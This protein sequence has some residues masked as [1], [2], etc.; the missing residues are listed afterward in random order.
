VDFDDDKLKLLGWGG[1]KPP[2]ALERPGQARALE[3]PREVE[4][5]IFPDWKSP[6]EGGKVAAYKIERRERPWLDAG[7]AMETEATLHNQE[8]GKEGEYRVIAVS[9]ADEAMP[10]NTVMAVLLQR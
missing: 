2:K 7:M 5:W 10:N 1:R 4:G 9:K 3:A 8:R 6:S